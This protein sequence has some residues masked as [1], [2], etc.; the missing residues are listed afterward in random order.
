MEKVETES[1]T[2]NSKKQ[3]TSS[4]SSRRGCMKGKGGD[5]NGLCNF[6]GV[7]QRK[8]GKWVAE[9]RHPGSRVWLGTFDTSVEAALAYDD[10]AL[11]MYGPSANLNLPNHADDNPVSTSTT[12]CETTG[13]TPDL[14]DDSY[15]EISVLLDIF[16]SPTPPTLLNW[17]QDQD[18]LS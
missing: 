1:C 9:I 4:Y 7:R 15:N 6:R 12:V 17:W 18:D 10:A 2:S 16:Q 13:A 11:K 5:E 8:W 14:S 3:K